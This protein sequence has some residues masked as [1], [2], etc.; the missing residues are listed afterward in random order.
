MKHVV[1]K[2][3]TRKEVVKEYYTCDFCGASC[4]TRGYD[5]S[6]VTIDARLGACYESDNRDVTSIDCCVKCWQQKALPA[7]LAIGAKPR[8]WGPY[9]DEPV[10]KDEA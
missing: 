8:N 7:L 3:V 9:D 1:R 4:E 5:T 6:E 10:V 2:V